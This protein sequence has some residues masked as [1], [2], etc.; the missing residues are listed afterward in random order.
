MADYKKIIIKA[1]PS[2]WGGPITVEPKPGRD[3]IASITGTEGDIQNLA[4][5]KKKLEAAGCLVMPSN[6][7]AALL[8]VHVMKRVALRWT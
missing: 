5:Q 7:Q 3:V 2:G 4:E 6:Y 8:A 1:G